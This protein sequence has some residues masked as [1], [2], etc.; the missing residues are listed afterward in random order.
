MA[1]SEEELHDSLLLLHTLRTLE[2]IHRQ[3]GNRVNKADQ[4]A[5]SASA[6]ENAIRA[7]TAS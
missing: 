5:R 1:L 6:I 7:D 3:M 4:T 2:D